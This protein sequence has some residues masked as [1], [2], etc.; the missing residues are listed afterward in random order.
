[1]WN[2][3]L[4]Q[5]AYF[6][7]VYSL[8]FLRVLIGVFF[9]PTLE[10]HL[11]FAGAILLVRPISLVI[12]GTSCPMDRTSTPCG[13]AETLSAMVERALFHT[14]GSIIVCLLHLDRRRTWL[15]SRRQAEA[16]ARRNR[17]TAA[18]A[19]AAAAAAAE[20]R[21]HWDSAD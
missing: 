5:Q 19:T 8:Q 2:Q 17:R 3:V 18:A 4:K 9:S 21:E 15:R 14:A 16:D 7:D 20:T 6:H 10:E 1:M 13:V 11:V 12:F